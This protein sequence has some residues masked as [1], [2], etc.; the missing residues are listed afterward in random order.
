MF[1]EGH[2][3]LLR[4]LASEA[5]VAIENARLFNEEQKK[6]RQLTLLNNVSEPCD[7]HDEPGRDAREDC[8]GDRDRSDVR[9]HRNR[10]DR[11][12]DA[13]ELLIQAEAGTR[14]D[15]IGRRVLLGEGLIGHVA[16]TGHLAAVR[17]K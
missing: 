5:T 6:S 8:G 3:E 7:L 12:F 16:R 14:R 13:K 1:D 17:W 10:D 15:A 11:L 9:S 2:V 4:V